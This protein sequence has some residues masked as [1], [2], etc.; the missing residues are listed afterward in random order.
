MDLALYY[1][2]ESGMTRI[3]GPWQRLYTQ[4]DVSFASICEYLF[5][6]MP[7]QRCY[8]CLVKFESSSCS[9]RIKHP[10]LL[11]CTK[12]TFLKKFKDNWP[13]VLHERCS[14]ILPLD[15]QANIN[16]DVT[17]SNG[18]K[19]PANFWFKVHVH[20]STLLLHL[21]IT[22]SPLILLRLCHF[23]LRWLVS[24]F[25]IFHICIHPLIIVIKLGQ[26]SWRL[27]VIASASTIRQ[28]WATFPKNL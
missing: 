12:H 11:Q 7:W 16:S 5:S 21:F 1:R 23:A 13:R 28:K 6:L 4:A 8:S 18:V 15:R 9:A 2:T 25:L 26:H 22:R 19:A 10:C 3:S 27:L 20:D 17:W 14:N 24:F